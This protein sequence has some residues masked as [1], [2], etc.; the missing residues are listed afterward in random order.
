MAPSRSLPLRRALPW[1]SPGCNLVLVVI[2]AVIALVRA[3]HGVHLPQAGPR[4]RSRHRQDAG[5]R[6]SRRGG[7]QAYLARQFKTLSIFV[8]LVFV[9]LLLLPADTAGVRWGRSVFFVVGAAVLGRRSA[10]SA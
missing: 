2:V 1:T 5:D 6:R 10:T 8:V 7:R 4:R 3:R 9:L